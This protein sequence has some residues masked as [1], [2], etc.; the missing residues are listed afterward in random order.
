MDTNHQEENREQRVASTPV[1]QKEVV[2][3]P[4][5]PGYQN[6]PPPLQANAEKNNIGLTGFILSIVAIVISLVPIVGW[7][8]WL[9]GLILSIIGVFKKPRGFAIAGLVISL[10]GLIIMFV[11]LG[12][13]GTAIAV[14]AASEM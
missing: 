11:V 7:L 9:L 12:V 3:P 8:C 1:Q 6:F 14:A 5:N 13:L 10:I 4:A 2:T